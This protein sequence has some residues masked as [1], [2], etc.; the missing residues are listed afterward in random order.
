MAGMIE[1]LADS[2][3]AR[4]AMATRPELMAAS[5]ANAQ[6][7]LFPRDPGGLSV[8]ERLAL[9]ARI[10]AL[11]AD[12][13]LAAEY[14]ARLAGQAAGPGLDRLADP[15]WT[16]GPEDA[17]LAAIQRHVDLVTGSPRDATRQDIAALV[18][19]GVAEPD[20]VRLSQVVAFVN[21]QLRVVAGL[22]LIG[23]AA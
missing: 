5:E 12:A 22:R 11:N 14:G 9:A 8:A 10:A 20:V 13:A 2:P 1:A 18:A 23:A 3:A 15:G 19:A 6:A 7:A 21:Y 16:A 4:A 17:R